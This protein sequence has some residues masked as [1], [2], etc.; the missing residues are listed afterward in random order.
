MNTNDATAAVTSDQ[1]AQMRLQRRLAEAF[2][3][4]WASLVDPHD[5]QFDADGTRWLEIGA[6]GRMTSPGGAPFTTEE[7]HAAIRAR[8]RAL[9]VTNEFAINGHENRINYLVG[10]GHT[11]EAVARVAGSASVELLRRVQA[12]IDE[13]VQVNRWHRRQQ[14]IVRRQDRD[15]ESFLQFFPAA[16]GILRVRF[17]EPDQVRTP[18]SRAADP[19]ASFGIQT[20][21]DDVE[22]ALGYWIDGQWVEAGEIQHRKAN[23][24]ANVK[25]GLPLFVPVMKN[26][27]R[28][29]KLLRNMSVVS[30][31]QSAIALIRKHAAGTR[32]T[33]EQFVGSQADAQ[34]VTA[35]GRTVNYKRYAP[36]SILDTYGGVEYDFPAAGIDAANFVKVLQAE[37]RAIA[38]RLVMPEFMLT[39]DAS[40]ANYASTLVAEG[41]AVKM[42][43]RLQ[44]ELVADDR[45]VLWRAVQ[46]AVDAGRL[47]P[48]VFELVEIQSDPPRVAV[49]D[50]LKDVHAY[51]LELEAGILSPQT[52]S[53]RRGLDYEQEQAN[54]AVHVAETR[55]ATPAE[56]GRTG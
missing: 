31:I 34:R 5:D 17:V 36:G 3:D 2:D 47:P 39:S 49:R 4:L 35:G 25:R 10:P 18:P 27:R 12:V 43:Q 32:T 26:L 21:P 40:N 19:A 56:L 30:E 14:E 23:V 13:F 33:V 20:M 29:E 22:T 1:A 46:T 53:R 50:E 51:R 52:W 15:G 11:Y 45:E 9:A 42:F 6:D 8:C 55:R 28:A 16:D 41:P 38:S 54:I 48:E 44:A 24:D 7:Q 37:L